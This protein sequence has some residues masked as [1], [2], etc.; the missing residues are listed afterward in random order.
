MG[1][2][3]GPLIGAILYEWGGFTYPFWAF[4]IIFLILL[5]LSFMVN[6]GSGNSIALAQDYEKLEDQIQKTTYTQLMRNKFSF[7]AIGSVFIGI[8][9]YTH[10]DPTMA[11][12]LS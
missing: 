8:F 12:E 2:C 11:L 6:L 1:L 10:I 9:Q 7:F 5:V 3:L 4:F